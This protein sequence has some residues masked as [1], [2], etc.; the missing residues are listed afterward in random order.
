M[1]VHLTLQAE[2]GAR[3]AALVAS[4]K[5][6]ITF[7]MNYNSILIFLFASKPR[8][9]NAAAQ[10]TAGAS[11]TTLGAPAAAAGLPSRFRVSVHPNSEFK[12]ILLIKNQNTFQIQ[13]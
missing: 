13:F 12:T 11:A 6:F 4:H 3:Q 5:H 8:K 7:F 1:S 2:D 10:K 9:F